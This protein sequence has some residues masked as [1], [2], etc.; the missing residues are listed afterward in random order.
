MSSTETP[1]KLALKQRRGLVREYHL[2]GL[3]SYAISDR[4]ESDHG[5]S[6]TDQTVRNDIEWLKKNV[7]EH[8]VSLEVEAQRHRTGLALD[9][10]ME[11]VLNG[12]LEN[13][14]AL[15][16]L[17]ERRAKLMGLDE[18]PKRAQDPDDG[19]SDPINI[20][21]QIMKENDERHGDIDPAE[22]MRAHDNQEETHE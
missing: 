2:R 19:G 8:D 18:A 6:V 21:L 10:V 15:V 17:E 5:V 22:F 11:A 12:D 14:T 1:K 3:S 7:S 4:L 16:R 9:K 13:V 20:N